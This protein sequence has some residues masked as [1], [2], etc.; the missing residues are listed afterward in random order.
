MPRKEYAES[1]YVAMYLLVYFDLPVKTKK[2]R[3]EYA[4]FR[5]AL[6]KDG[7]TMLQYS[8]Y[9]RYC[10]DNRV[11]ERHKKRI[12]EALPPKGDVKTMA[13]TSKIYEKME[14]FI[15]RKE[16]EGAKAPDVCTFY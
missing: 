5:K 7:F 15:G 16:V 4:L 1:G 10:A 8:V 2:D 13:V 12:R 14:N 11:V 6:L 9:S 3:K